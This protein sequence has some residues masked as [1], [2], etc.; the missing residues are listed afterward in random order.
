MYLYKLTVKKN[1]GEG[2]DLWYPTV[3]MI[4]MYTQRI[5]NFA[6]EVVMLKAATTDRSLNYLNYLIAIASYGVKLVRIEDITFR[7]D[8]N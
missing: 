5:F 7:L 1:T 3:C 4:H 6:Y 2:H 8:A